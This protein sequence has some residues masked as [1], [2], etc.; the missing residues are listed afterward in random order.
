M[1]A[2][3]RRSARS[4]TSGERRPR[5]RKRP[6]SSTACHAAQGGQGRADR[7]CCADLS[8]PPSNAERSE[9]HT[10]IFL[11]LPAPPLPGGARLSLSAF[12]PR[13]RCPRGKAGSSQV[14]SRRIASASGRGRTG[15]ANGNAIADA[16]RQR[17]ATPRHARTRHRP[18]RRSEARHRADPESPGRGGAGQAGHREGEVGSRKPG[19]NAGNYTSG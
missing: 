18:T 5:Q 1:H 16:M 13:P 2:R 10:A 6:A 9:A 15:P 8:R 19:P 4:D 7:W 11:P 12:A 14:G 3:S 17:A